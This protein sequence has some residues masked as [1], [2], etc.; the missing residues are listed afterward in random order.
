MIAEMEELRNEDAGRTWTQARGSS[1]DA[2]AADDAAYPSVVTVPCR[3]DA[4]RTA[5]QALLRQVL[6]RFSS[7]N[8]DRLLLYLRDWNTQSRHALFAQQVLAATMRTVP[9]SKLRACPSFRDVVAAL[10]PYTIRHLERMDRMLESTYLLDYTLASMHQLM[11]E[12]AAAASAEPTTPPP[13]AK[14]TSTTRKDAAPKSKKTPKSAKPTKKR[15][16]M[17]KAAVSATAPRP[18]RRQRR[19]SKAT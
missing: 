15:P 16:S 17:A 14:P 7:D 3:A 8:L 19:A 1:V 11:P 13:A 2:D 9:A 6:T 12:E 5:G 18:A 10:T 4:K